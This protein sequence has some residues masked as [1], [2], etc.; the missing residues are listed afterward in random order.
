[1]FKDSSSFESSFF[2]N[3]VYNSIIPKDHPLRILKHIA[4]FNELDHELKHLYSKNGQ[5][6]YAPSLMMRILI[7][8]YLYNLSDTRTMEFVKYNIAAKYYVGLA[9]DQD[10]PDASDLTYFRQRLG[11]SYFQQI[12][13]RTLHIAANHGLVIGEIALI[14]STHTNAKIRALTQ[15]NPNT[16][17]DHNDQD[18][19]FGRKNKDHLFHGYKNHIAVESH[20]NLITAATTTPGNVHDS[21]EFIPLMEQLQEV[22]PPNIVSADK[23]YDSE[24][25]HDHLEQHD[26]F[27][28][29]ILKDNRFQTQAGEIKVEDPVTIQENPYLERYLDDR[30]DRGRHERYRVEQVFAEAKKYHGL[31][32]SRYLGLENNLLQTLLTATVINLKHI[33]RVMYPDMHFY[34]VH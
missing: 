27:S 12:F 22:A 21:Q 3:F 19:D 24:E 17:D 18:A 8:Q 28:A 23:A 6:A 26:I 32:R 10:V 14:D 16:K 4:S 13:Q 25:I 29:V 7:L 15:R 30:Y 34:K 1:M 5:H 33:M 11:D 31:S 20:H 2:G 9:V